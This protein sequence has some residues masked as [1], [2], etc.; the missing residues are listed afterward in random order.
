[1]SGNPTPNWIQNVADRARVAA[2]PRNLVLLTLV[3]TP[4][5]ALWYAITS[6]LAPD[7]TAVLWPYNLGIHLVITVVFQLMTAKPVSYGRKGTA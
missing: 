5:I 1:M 7:Q 6:A 3:Q 4:L 2:A